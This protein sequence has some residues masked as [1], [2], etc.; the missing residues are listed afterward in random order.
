MTWT[1]VKKALI[2]AVTSR[3]AKNALSSSLDETRGSA[4]PR[5]ASVALARIRRHV[6]ESGDY[7]TKKL[8]PHAK[9]QRA[10]L[11]KESLR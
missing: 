7:G 8:L 11:R 1:C 6:G 5:F 10:G 3:R 4:H 9:P 2:V